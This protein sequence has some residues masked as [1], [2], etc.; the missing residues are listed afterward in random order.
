MPWQHTGVKPE[1]A[2]LFTP[3]PYNTEGIIPVATSSIIEA[4]DPRLIFQKDNIEKHRVDASCAAGQALDTD[5][6]SMGSSTMNPDHHQVINLPISKEPTALL[7]IALGRDGKEPTAQQLAELSEDWKKCRRQLSLGLAALNEVSQSYPT[8]S[9]ADLLRYNAPTTPNAIPIIWDISDSTR[10]V[11]MHDGAVRTF[12]MEFGG[13]VLD[14]VRRHGGGL[15]NPTGD[16]QNVFLPIP[17]ENGTRLSLEKLRTFGRTVAP[18]LS[19]LV[20]AASQVDEYNLRLTV[21]IGR[22]ECTMSGHGQH[23]TQGL[24][25]PQLFDMTKLSKNQPRDKFTVALDDSAQR[26]LGPNLPHEVRAVLYD[27]H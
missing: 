11:E 18:I 22:V 20:H 10:T 15:I 2:T 16:G 7:Q 8:G 3:D 5:Y 25:S 12:V 19:E 13:R 4:D 27:K 21:G 6:I 23:A 14:I 24:F 9:V 17:A 26:I 1:A